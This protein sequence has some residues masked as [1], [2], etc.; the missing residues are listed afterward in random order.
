[1]HRKTRKSIWLTLLRCSGTRLQYLWDV[2]ALVLHIWRH[3]RED[4][5]WSQCIQS[6]CLC[7]FISWVSFSKSFL[8]IVTLRRQQARPPA[9][10][11]QSGHSLSHWFFFN[12]L[13]NEMGL[14]SSILR[15]RPRCKRGWFDG[16]VVSTQKSVPS[17][18]TKSAVKPEWQIPFVILSL[19]P[20]T[21]PSHLAGTH[22]KIAQQVIF[23]LLPCYCFKHNQKNPWMSSLPYSPALRWQVECWASVFVFD[24]RCFYGS[25]WLEQGLSYLVLI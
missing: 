9:L 21:K 10:S 14:S 23:V 22:T 15:A 3:F 2:P 12:Q 4:G 6:C 20:V 8:F 7:D 17:S 1:M 19:G 11:P 13:L 16:S 18:C 24:R 5:D 25:R